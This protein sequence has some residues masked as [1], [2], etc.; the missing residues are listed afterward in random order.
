MES[1]NKKSNKGLQVLIIILVIAL[2]ITI[3][4]DLLMNYVPLKDLFSKTVNYNTQKEVT[5]TDKGIADAV[6]K[7]YDATVIVEVGNGNKLAGWGSGVVYKKDDK[8]GYI[9]TNHHVI[10][11]V[12]D[13]MIEFS[14]ESTVEAELIG[15][16]EYA[17]IAVLRVP[18]K[19]IKAVAEIGKSNDVRV[20][21]TVFAVGTP[22]SLEYSFTVTRGIL[23]GKNRMVEMTSSKSKTSNFFGQKTSESWYMNLLQIDA[24]IN[25][26]NSGGPLANSNGEVIGITN[27]K[28]SSSYSQTSIENMGFAIP[29][30]DALSVAQKLID[31]KGKIKRPVL[32]VTMTN[33]EGASYYDLKISDSIKEGAVVVDVSKDSTADAAGLKKGDVI[34]KLD[35]YNISDYEYLK[36]YLY[37][38]NVGD[39]VK[40]TYNRNGK[41]HTTTVTLKG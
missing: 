21:D 23:S 20:G 4:V 26:G 9:L 41:E 36:Y 29:I 25:S 33:V 6:E 32:G 10:D 15:S 22:V 12:E 19:S 7:L 18:V 35:D 40:I 16:D 11:E 30:E 13:I 2:G 5:V 1:E 27:S 3:I 31:N 14:D 17:D 28:L 24:S 34:T 37:R 38:Y 39:K 8:Y